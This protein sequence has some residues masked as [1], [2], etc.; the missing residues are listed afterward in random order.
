VR[1]YEITQNLFHHSIQVIKCH[2]FFMLCTRYDFSVSTQPLAERTM[3]KGIAVDN[4]DRVETDEGKTILEVQCEGGE[5]LE[6]DTDEIGVGGHDGRQS[7]LAEVEQE[8]PDPTDTASAEKKPVIEGFDGAFAKFVKTYSWTVPNGRTVKIIPQ[9]DG[10][11]GVTY[12]VRVYA[13]GVI[14]PLAIEDS[15]EPEMVDQFEIPS[16]I[17]DEVVQV[18]R[19]LEA[20]FQRVPGSEKQRLIDQILSDDTDTE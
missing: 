17:V 9:V 4:I 5:T 14:G 16:P 12:P 2:R 13:Q 20:Q 19:Q 10:D 11:G 15:L 3:S 18:Q 7:T 1:K 8:E 6:V